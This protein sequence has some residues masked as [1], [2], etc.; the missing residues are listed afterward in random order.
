MKTEEL[1]SDSQHR[2]IDL[3]KLLGAAAL[4]ALLAHLTNFYFGSPIP[5]R[6]L[7]P[8]CGWA[9]VVLLIG[10]KRY[11]W[12][13]FLGAF[14]VNLISG[15]PLGAAAG[16]ALGNTLGALLGA[17][18][19]TRD[20]RFDSR[21]RSLRDY[22]RLVVLGG[23]G[24]GIGALV[25]VAALLASGLLAPGAF[26]LGLVHWW[27][28]DA[29]GIILIAPL[30]LVWRLEKNDW[31]E[32]QRVHVAA[33]LLGLTFL[34]GQAVFL[35]WF[36]DSIGLVAKGYVM[37][38]FI[39]WVAVRLGTWGTVAALVMVS[40][41][42]LLGAHYGTGFFANDIAATQLTNYWLYMAILSVVG[43]ALATHF[44]ERRLAE[45]QLR[46]LS[47][48]LQYV[49]EEE[50]AGIA[51]E[52]HDDLGGTLTAIK[53]EIYWL[54]RGLTA[55][56]E[57]EP[58]RERIESMSL[59]LDNAVGA[60]RRIITELRPTIL[61][62]LGLLAAIEWQAAQFQKR[63][64]IVCRVNCIGDKG[65]LDKQRS[66]ALFRIFQEALT[67]VLRH[68]GA[69]RVE[70][71]FYHDDTEVM[72][73]IRDN[74]CGMPGGHVIA[75]HSYGIRGMFE[76]VGQLGGKIRFDNR[77]EGGLKVAVTLPLSANHQKEEK[78]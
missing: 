2:W 35:D 19:I 45:R 34:A 61:D 33:L 71:V 26:L 48:H 4:Y 65:D 30:F 57:S 50:K 17:W 53:M 38:L 76:R 1:H 22:L 12:G 15:N 51:R 74:G 59:L 72:L 20:G 21:L 40:I 60:T 31:L 9:L 54:A 25:G 7:E 5:I 23:T 75:P 55:G 64:G 56:N 14:L 29:L 3:L 67:N 43:M 44:A 11:A 37:F 16:I 6:I 78:T 42:A 52:I 8:A 46:D 49:R 47:A 70:V 73:K 18:L 28:G 36:H 77:P 62:D 24:S 66:I 58:L 10:G 68:S 13:I 39:T 27:M 69:S 32:M 63:T 41:Q